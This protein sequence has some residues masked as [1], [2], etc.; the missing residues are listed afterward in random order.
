VRRP[1]DADTDAL[2]THGRVGHEPRVSALG[3][4]DDGVRVVVVDDAGGVERDRGEV[5]V[6][7]LERVRRVPPAHEPRDHVACTW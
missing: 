7:A 6:D 4:R 5:P 1:V 3:E 2:D